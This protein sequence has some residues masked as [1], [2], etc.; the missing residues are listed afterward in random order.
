MRKLTLLLLLVAGTSHADDEILTVAVASNFLKTAQSIGDRYT[1]DYGVPVRFVSGST[2]KLYAQIVNGAPYDVFLA[3]DDE[4]P[5][6]LEK[7]DQTLDKRRI[8]YAYGRLALFTADNRYLEGGCETAFHNG[9]FERLA[10]ANPR[11]A[12]YG[13]A[14]QEYLENKGLWGEFAPRIV[15]GENVAQAT[16]FV[17]S[18]NATFGLGQKQSDEITCVWYP[19]RTE[20]SPIR[21]QAVVLAR[22]PHA[23][24]AVYFLGF[25]Q[26]EVSRGI[27]ADDGYLTE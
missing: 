11:T 24:A 25:L 3:A 8:T 9:T 21:Q 15:R 20:Y 17:I 7:A 13:R 12:P 1:E 5:R 16:H 19:A 6:I 22:T 23:D 18:G 2:G 14:A 4:R 10:I 26:Q 27:I